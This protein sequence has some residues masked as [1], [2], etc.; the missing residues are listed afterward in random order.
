[1]RINIVGSGNVATHL[2]KTLKTCGHIITDIASRDIDHAKNL[3]QS[4]NANAT[5]DLSRLSAADV[6]IISVSDNSIENVAQALLHTNSS[7]TIL[8]T[9]GATPLNVLSGFE[10]RGVLYPCMT[11]SKD[12]TIDLSKCPF[13]TEANT[14]KAKDQISEIVTSLGAR[15]IECDSERRAHIHVAAVFSSNFTNHMLSLTKQIMD[16]EHMPFDVL[17]P[18]VNQT[19][20]KGFKEQPHEAQTGPARRGDTLTI[21][22]HCKYLSFDKKLLKVYQTL[23]KSIEESYE[24]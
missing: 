24:I 22:S 4:V 9:S 3:A 18:L 14:Q 13:L 11:F 15:Q 6:T 17:E 8:H 5:T 12:D 16:K 10:N 20:R 19:I 2:A 21:E 1:M 23:T 7:Q